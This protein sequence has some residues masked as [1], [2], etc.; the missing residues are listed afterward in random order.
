VWFGMD[1]CLLPMEQMDVCCSHDGHRHV[2][3][4]ISW[5]VVVIV[6]GEEVAAPPM[7]EVGTRGARGKLGHS[8]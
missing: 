1:Q 6:R 3:R 4:W 7:E 8:H 2:R 5:D